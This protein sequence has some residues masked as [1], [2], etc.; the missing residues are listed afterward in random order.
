[1]SHTVTITKLPDEESDDYEYTFGGEHGPSCSVYVE[2]KRKAC[3]AM[4][5]DYE[6]GDER[7]R[8]G[9]EHFY[10][11]GDWLVESDL[12]SLRYVFEYITAAETFD[13]VAVGTYPVLIQWEDTWWLEVQNRHPIEV[14]S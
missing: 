7:F 14:S 9:K 6:P 8:H 12:C 2:C 4:N 13:G 10:R 11:D 3:Q 1:M 5:P